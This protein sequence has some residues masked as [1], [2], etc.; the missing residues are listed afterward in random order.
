[1]LTA[2]YA[3]T[4]FAARDVPSLPVPTGLGPLPGYGQI[5]LSWKSAGAPPAWFVVY[6][7]DAGKPAQQ[8]VVLGKRSRARPCPSKRATV[9]VVRPRHCR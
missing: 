7:N 6:L 4:S 3:P 1:M 5:G 9:H 8:Y 2:I